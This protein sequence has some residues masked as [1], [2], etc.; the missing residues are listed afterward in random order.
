MHISF[1]SLLQKSFFPQ[2]IYLFG[3]SRSQWWHVGSVSFSF[4]K[5][6]HVGSCSLT[7]G[8]TQAPCN[9]CPKSQ[10]LAYQGSP[11]FL[12]SLIGFTKLREKRIT[13]K[14]PKIQRRKEDIYS[15]FLHPF[16]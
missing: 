12:S 16:L 11:S 10:P 8:Q 4:F 13:F 14:N 2:F 15:R 5:L 3:S 9:G 1:P 7:R 6:C